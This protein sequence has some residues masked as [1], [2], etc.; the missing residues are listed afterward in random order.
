MLRT[1]KCLKRGV[2]AYA[3]HVLYLYHFYKMGHLYYDGGVMDQP[4]PY[5]AAMETVDNVIAT[6]EPKDSG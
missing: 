3:K 1:S 4:A 2:T 6:L 5:L